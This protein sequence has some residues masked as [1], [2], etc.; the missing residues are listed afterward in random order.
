VIETHEQYLVLRALRTI[1]ARDVAVFSFFVPGEMVMQIADISR[2]HH[3]E[4][5]SLQGFQRKEIKNHV[6][7]IVE[8]LNNMDVLFPNAIILALG[9]EVDFKQARG[10]DPEGVTDIADI[11]TISIPIR[12]E[13]SRVAWIVDGQ[14]RSIALAKTNNKNIP[15]PVIAFYAPDLETQRSQFILVNKAKPLP[16]RLINELLPEVDVLMPRELAVRKIPSEL[17]NLLNKDP[18]SPF[19]K[20][21]K[22]AS[23]DDSDAAVIVDTSLIEIIKKSISNPLG[24]LAQF[25]G[26]GSESSDINSMYKA[27]LM[28]WNEVKKT[29]PDA[30]GLPP[31]K[32]RLMHSAGIKAMGVLMDKIYARAQASSD[33]VEEIRSSLGK[34]APNCHWSSGHWQGIGLKWDEIQNVN[35]H[36]KMLSDYLIR[37]DYGS[38]AKPV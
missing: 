32:S 13:G 7:S 4:M 19:Y 20:L 3:D 31:T 2:V 15:V 6:N 37:L 36:V 12:G 23:H 9:Q 16:T 35:S 25:K 8:Y 38:K 14:Q 26:F 30:W 18:Q 17:C 5:D 22:R 11:G 33:P 29:F 1:Q 10:R 28:F 34:I 24:A 21:I 27:L